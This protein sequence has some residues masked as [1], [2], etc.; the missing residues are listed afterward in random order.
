VLFDL[1]LFIYLILFNV[2]I[3]DLTC[4]RILKGLPDGCSYVGDY[5]WSI[6]FDNLSDKK[7]L[8]SKVQRLLNQIQTVFHRHGMDLDEKKTEL[9]VIYK[10][11]QKRKQWEMEAN[12]WPLQWHDKTIH[13]KGNTRWLEYHLDR[14][15]NWH[16]HVDTCVQR[17]L[18]K[19]QQ[20]RRFMAA[21]GINRKL[22]RTVSWSTSMATATYGL[23][24]IYGGQHSYY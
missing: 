7:E 23:D 4:G 13:F 17:A 19:Q 24:V 11:N 6:P 10:A 9:A 16:A 3:F 15:L 22:A 8:A 20:V 1:T 18:W 12:W 14:C 21:Y 5:A 2:R